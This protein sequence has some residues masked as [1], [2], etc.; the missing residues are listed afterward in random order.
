M[1]GRRHALLL[2]L[3]L[4]A[5]GDDGPVRRDFPPLH[6]DYLTALRL[7][8]ASLSIPEPPPPG[9]LE[10]DSPAPAGEALVRMATDRLSAAGSSGRAAFVIDEVRVRRAGDG[11]DG[12]LAVHLDVLTTDGTRAG[13]AEARVARSQTGIRDLR[14][15]LYELT[16]QMMDDM[17]VEFEFQVRRSLKDWLQTTSTEPAAAPVQRQDLSAPGQAAQ[18]RPAVPPA[19]M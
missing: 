10:A 1:I 9:P 6:Y 18:P 17:N 2:P 4:A 7:N 12:A 14:T 3:S 16:R 8:V 11:F 15:A 5:C 13:F 19:A